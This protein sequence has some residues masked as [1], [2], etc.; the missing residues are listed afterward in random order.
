MDDRSIISASMDG[1]CNKA[2]RLSISRIPAL[3]ASLFK[4]IA[5]PGV[6]TDGSKGWAFEQEF[7][8]EDGVPIPQRL[9][10]V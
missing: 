5:S 3:P 10:S 4:E 7:S 9:K 8:M 6:L 2:A 1:A